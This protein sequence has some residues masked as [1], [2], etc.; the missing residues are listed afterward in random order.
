[1]ENLSN[2]LDFAQIFNN[3]AF[4]QNFE[5]KYIDFSK[6][7]KNLDFSLNIRKSR[8]LSKILEIISFLQWFLIIFYLVKSF[9]NLDFVRNFRKITIFLNIFEKSWFWSKKFEFPIYSKF[10]KS[11][12][13]GPMFR[14]S[15][16]LWKFLKMSLMLKIYKNLDSGLNFRKSSVQTFENLDIGQNCRKI[17]FFAKK[18]WISNLSNF[19]KFYLFC[20][21]FLISNL[22]KI[23]D[24]PDLLQ[25]TK[26]HDLSEIYEKSQICSKFPERFRL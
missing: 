10:T 26:N 14:K 17:L 6:F 25:L 13:F 3:L 1:M 16:F 19:R 4:F 18:N 8:L 7:S 22:V 5:E 23:M 24:N 12:D 21:F 15:R 9:D 11:V 20:H 2:N